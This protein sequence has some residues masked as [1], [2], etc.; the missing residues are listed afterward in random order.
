MGRAI[1]LFDV[2]GT[3]TPARQKIHNDIREFL[4][5]ARARVP[6]AVV[7]GSDLAKI[8]EQLADNKDDF[9]VEMKFSPCSV[10]IDE[11]NQTICFLVLSQFDYVF[12]ENGLV[13]FKGSEQFPSK[14]IQDHIGEEKLQEL[15]NF[16]LKYFSEIKLPVKRGNFIE[17]RK[18]MLNLSPIGRSCSQSERDHFV[19][20]DKEH[21]IRE[22][23]VRALQENF[24]RYGLCF[25]IG[26]QISVDAYPVGWDKTYCLQYIEKDY[27]KIY[28]FGDKTMPGGNDHAIFEDPRTIGHTVV[29]PADMK[30]QVEQLLKEL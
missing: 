5:K 28:F 9:R 19:L 13:G 4:S 24:S 7:G 11:Q 12:S 20:Y 3:L 27:D 25:V 18:G 30:K 29:D 14:T 22:K 16:T 6:L 21:Q 10:F 17:F 26:G 2:D 1:L 23:F 15:I 8:I